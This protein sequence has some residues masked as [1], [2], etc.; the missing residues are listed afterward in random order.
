MKKKLLVMLLAAICCAKSFGQIIGTETE[1][2]NSA[3]T[4]NLLVLGSY[5]PNAARDTGCHLFPG[6]DFIDMYRVSV[7][8]QGVLAVTVPVNS[9]GLT[10]E[11]IIRDSATYTILYDSWNVSPI[12][13][14]VLVCGGAYYI[15]IHTYTSATNANPYA[16]NVDFYPDITE[17]N[18]TA[19]DA[20]PLL[21]ND[22]VV[23]YLRGLNQTLFGNVRDRDIYKI[24][25]ID[26]G[27]LTAKIPINA[28]AIGFEIIITDSA[29]GTMIRDDWSTVAGAAV[30]DTATI[31]PG[32]YYI[33]VKSHTYNV[34]PNP[35]TLYVNLSKC[36]DTTTPPTKIYGLNETSE[37]V[38]IYPNPNNGTFSII[39]PSGD[40]FKNTVV[41]V[42]DMMGRKIREVQT[43]RPIEMKLD[44]PAGVYFITATANG[45]RYPLKIIIK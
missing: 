20:F 5:A 25:N 4:A 21:A 44:E 13:S 17:C 28:T 38:K 37:T 40:A 12:T 26:C 29:T 45:A 24:R 43:D 19:F 6:G 1:P 2:N 27:F 23:G 16:L 10:F 7:P 33:E 8:G 31:S 3:G 22:T 41:T 9:T 39:I 18:N 11:I 34:D 15:T 36:P 35:Y 14:E 32:T 30:T 42:T